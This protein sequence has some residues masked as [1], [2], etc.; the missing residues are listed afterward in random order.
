MDAITL[1]R[2]KKKAADPTSPHPPPQN[3]HT[4][5]HTQ[6]NQKPTVPVCCPSIQACR[7]MKRSRPA[8]PNI[9]SDTKTCLR[10]MTLPE[11]YFSAFRITHGSFL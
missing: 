9:S 3:T 11:G 10:F 6:E 1:T 7:Y 2:T 4:H 5:A 8:T